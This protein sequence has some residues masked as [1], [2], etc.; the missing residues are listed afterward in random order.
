MHWRTALSTC[1]ERARHQ[2]K[3]HL[4]SG[5][6]RVSSC[7]PH[8][9]GESR[10][11]HVSLD[12]Q[13]MLMASAMGRVFVPYKRLCSSPNSWLQGTWIMGG[14]TVPM[15]DPQ[16]PLLPPALPCGTQGKNGC[17]KPRSGP[18]GAH[19]TRARLGLQPAQLQEGSGGCRKPQAGRCSCGLSFPLSLHSHGG[20][21]PPR[22]RACP[23]MRPP[24]VTPSP[25]TLGRH[26]EPPSFN[27]QSG[28]GS[29]FT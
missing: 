15:K 22:Q 4:L 9:P 20:C 11:S 10:D 12:P 18:T 29:M 8:G 14:V 16:G 23:Y 3:T 7:V 1:R 25:S 21:V 19:G 24:A 17:L 5:L 13:A 26:Q 27:L 2:H 6:V 28:Y